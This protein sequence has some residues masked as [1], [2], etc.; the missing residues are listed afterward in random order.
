MESFS[1]T[2]LHIIKIELSASNSRVIP[3]VC[4]M[5]WSQ[6]KATTLPVQG[7]KDGLSVLMTL[8]TFCQVWWT[9]FFCWAWISWHLS[10][11][12]SD[13]TPSPP[14]MVTWWSLLST[15]GAQSKWGTWPRWGLATCHQGVCR[16][17]HK[18][19]IA[20][21]SQFIKCFERVVFGHFS[22]QVSAYHD[23]LKFAHRNSV[24]VADTVFHMLFRVFSQLVHLQ[25]SCFLIALTQSFYTTQLHILVH[26]LVNTGIWKYRKLSGTPYWGVPPVLPLSTF[27]LHL[28]KCTHSGLKITRRQLLAL[29]YQS[30]DWS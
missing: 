23:L 18:R 2:T 26:K 8:T 4:D 13:G 14:G 29:K 21:T 28:N 25:E 22:R 27:P 15:E 30:K 17:P 12:E 16:P 20:L 3:K 1:S 5:A 7:Y 11:R 19:H 9:W 10:L 6:S 24:R